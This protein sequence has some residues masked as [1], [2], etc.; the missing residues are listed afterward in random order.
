VVK[1]LLACL[2]IATLLVACSDEPVDPI[3]GPNVDETTGLTEREYF[4][5]KVVPMYESLCGTSACHAAKA[6]RFE[7]LNE[8]YFL[9]PVDEEGVVSGSE[10][11]DKAYE[12]SIEKLSGAG[13]KFGDLVRKPL[14]EA[15]GGLAHKGGAQ[16]RSMED[17][18][19]AVLLTWA[20]MA[21]PPAEEALPSLIER[22]RWDVQPVLAE[23]SCMLSSC[24]GASASNF[25]I[26]DP[27]MVGEFDAH[28]TERNYKKVQ[29]HLNFE[30]P[31][32][33]LSRLIRKTIPLDQGGIPHRGG[34][35][36]FD[37]SSGDADLQVIVDFVN[38][39]RAEMGDADKGVL[40][41]IVFVATDP[42]PRNQ[43]DISVWQPGG[44]VYSLIPAVPGGKLTNIS[45]AHH[46]LP[47]D[48]RDP[49][50]SYDGTRIAF[51]MRRDQADCLNIYTM[52][53]D[54]SDLVQVTSDS[55][56]LPNGIKVSNVEPVWGPDDRIYFVSTRVGRIAAH[57]GFPISNVFH[58]EADGS[59]MLQMTFNAGYEYAPAWRF[60]PKPG[61]DRPEH[62]TLDLTFTATR[63]V[64][65]T[66]KGALMRVPP[67]FHA[68][69][70]PH[71][72]TQHP[73][74]QI[75]TQMTQ[76]PDLREPLIL[77]DEANV[78]EGGALAMIDRNLG[79]VIKDGGDPSVVNYIAGLQ[80]L[81]APGEDVAHT[82]FSAAGYY[83][84]PIA[85][86]D[87]GIIV[88]RDPRAID[89]NDPLALP[90][91]ALERL[92]IEDLPANGRA[93]VRDRTVLV[94][95]AGKIETDPRPIMRKRREEVGDPLHHL[96][97]ETDTGYVM[98]FDQAVQLTVAAEDSPSNT[99]DFD[100]M[101]EHIRYVRLVEEVPS[102]PGEIA[103]IGRGG[104][105]VR[106]II[107]EFPSTSDQS[108]YV[109]MP[110]GVPYFVQALDD[111]RAAATTFNQWF[112]V[113]PGEKLTQ[114]TRREVWDTR[115][116][117]CHGSISGVPGDT[118]A[119]PDVLAEAS[120]VVA[121]YDAETDTDKA[122]VPRG[123][124]PT[125][126]QTV[127]FEADIQPVLSSKCATAGC[128]VAGGA[129]LDLS[130]RA[131]VDGFSGSYEALTAVGTASKNDFEYVDP[132]SSTA[133]NSYLAEV[134]HGG[135]LDA[136]R[137]YDSAACAGR[138]SL[139]LNERATFMRWMDLGANYRGTT[140]APEPV[141][142]TY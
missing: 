68:D 66:M 79:P 110:A 9:F 141:L 104:H 125:E 74:Y 83:R 111:N 21:S 82:G 77:A 140:T 54:G 67:D 46:S 59:G 101:A 40:D 52:N 95:I 112:F 105:G 98:T 122:P 10:R 27:G 126:R 49:A 39:A 6:D 133:R 35:A 47:A 142:P 100:A 30:T 138:D 44:D 81:G 71:Y 72:G 15:L 108:M 65:D 85:L 102:D 63:M 1:H 12:R 36:F 25:L 50:V 114:V 45:A 106:R 93:V 20:E 129:P 91:T 132:K 94:D 128:H 51:A 78:W 75:F 119:R 60:T 2:C 121:N 70:H 80:K 17:E 69:Y 23:K 89:L 28:A 57:A 8:E 86:P 37:P 26:F 33:M 113:L 90:D 99:K 123:V 117:G 130:Q 87:G 34:N 137:T 31:D 11:L 4:E 22:Y 136:P 13:P 96:S 61:H 5:E 109:E 131:G 120:R 29:F 62:R 56:T 97:N 116:G 84:D 42:T 43:F 55:G 48:I 24:H 38:D 41:G 103:S 118:V 32:A 18:E 92:T 58:V 139:S 135:E 115:C 88:S 134:L 3:G 124:L 53:L 16:Y 107:G 19:L 73:E 14:D 76:L 64:G 127:D 7:K